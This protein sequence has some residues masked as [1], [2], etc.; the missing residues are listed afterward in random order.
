MLHTCIR[1]KVVLMTL[2]MRA[3]EDTG[4]STSTRKGFVFFSAY[5][6]LSFIFSRYWF[7]LCELV[8]D[9]YSSL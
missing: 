9:F 7:L 1:H 5:G 3:V 2:G 8:F 6:T 4:F